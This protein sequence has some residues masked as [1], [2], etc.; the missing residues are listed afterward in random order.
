MSTTRMYDVMS[1][2]G[3]KCAEIARN[4][5]SKCGE[6]ATNV[7][8]KCGE[9]LSDAKLSLHRKNNVGLFLISVN[10][11]NTILEIGGFAFSADA[12]QSPELRLD[13][14]AHF[15]VVIDSLELLEKVSS[16]MTSGTTIASGVANGAR[17]LQIFSMMASGKSIISIG[18]NIGDAL[19][20]GAN[21]LTT[22]GLIEENKPVVSPRLRS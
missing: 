12:R 18:E 1:I 6:I 19:V 15:L 3:S 13:A 16:K 4:A 5:G 10:I 22:L 7:G 11:L 2:V 8:S 14:L 17:L 20:H 9:V 21:V